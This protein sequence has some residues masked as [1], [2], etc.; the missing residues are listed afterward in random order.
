M[1]YKKLHSLLTLLAITILLSSTQNTLALGR[2][3]AVNLDL[4][5]PP[6]LYDINLRDYVIKARKRIQGLW[7][8]TQRAM[9]Q[10]KVLF[11]IERDGQLEDIRISQTS[12]DKEFDRQAMNAIFESAPFP[13]WPHQHLLIEANFDN[14]YQSAEEYADN[15]ARVQQIA[16]RREQRRQNTNSGYSQSAASNYRNEQVQPDAQFATAPGEK[17]W[18]ASDNRVIPLE[19]VVVEPTEPAQSGRSWSKPISYNQFKN[20]TQDQQIDY[21]SWFKQWMTLPVEQR[22][23]FLKVGPM[24]PHKQ[25]KKRS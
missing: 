18:T 2:R 16:E 24:T 25:T 17:T 12:G 10:V 13:P 21:L 3:N 8:P 22:F 23:A 15:K 1:V 14:H 9:P 11:L 20:I 19:E 6:K 4:T 7:V 5:N